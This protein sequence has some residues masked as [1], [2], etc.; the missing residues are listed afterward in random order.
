MTRLTTDDI[1][2]IADKLQAYDEE[3]IAKTGCTLAEIACQ[4][5]GIA[6]SEMKEIAAD[7]RVGVVPI[8]FGQ[9]IIAGFGDIVA[10][11]VSHVGCKAFVTQ[12]ADVA[13]WAES[14]DEKADILMFADDDR[15]IAVDVASRQVADNAVATAKGFVAGL[16]LMTGGLKQKNVLVI[17]CGPVGCAATEALIIADSIVSIYDINSSRSDA[18]ALR[19]KPISNTDID[20]VKDIEQALREHQFI[21]DATPTADIIRAH[22]ISAQTYVS[23]P[24]VPVGLDKDAQVKISNRLLHDPLQ[25]GVATMIACALKSQIE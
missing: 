15:F 17:G 1:A 5:T 10:A 25:I 11:I 21:V 20:I 14:L 7:I 2:S 8:T 9:G 13:G 23:A 19:I 4:A 18:L 6:E 22:H 16:G 24:G 3:L 12:Q